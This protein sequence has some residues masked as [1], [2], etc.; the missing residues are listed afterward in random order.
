M[1]NNFDYQLLHM[2]ASLYYNENVGQVEIAEMT[3][4]SQAKVSRLLA[5]ARERGIIQIHVEP[6]QPRNEILENNL[7]NRFSLKKAVVINVNSAQ[8]KS[9]KQKTVAHYACPEI[10]SLFKKNNIICI[11]AGR[12]LSYLVDKID[13]QNN[14]PGGHVLQTMGNVDTDIQ[15]YDAIELGRKLALKTSAR[16]LSLPSPAIASDINS[17]QVFIN[18]EQIKNVLNE[19]D[20]ADLALVGIGVLDD[21]VFVER[22]FLGSKEIKELKQAGVIGEICGRFFDANGKECETE[23]KNR[24][25]SLQFDQLG[26]I[27]LVAAMVCGEK[28]SNAVKAAIKGGLINCLITDNATAAALL[29][30]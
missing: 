7:L 14:L 26:K 13:F 17:Y 22:G 1:K 25:I 3:G 15:K 10:E 27:P 5:A 24:V 2:V 23:Y 16:F 18:H 29:K 9:Q 30:D 8:S 28:R 12:Q 11:S 19:M 4:V 20:H 6:F 21:S